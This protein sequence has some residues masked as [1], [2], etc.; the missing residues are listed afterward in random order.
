VPSYA[1]R[2]VC[3]QPDNALKGRGVVAY[4]LDDPPS[5]RDGA[6]QPQRG[7]SE[8]PMAPEMPKRLK[9]ALREA[10]MAAH[11]EELRRALVPLDAAF[12]RWRAGDVGSGELAELIHEFHD[13]PAREL[14]KRYNYGQLDLAVAHA[15]VAGILDRSRLPG[16]LVEALGRAIAFHEERGQT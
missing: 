15:I 2:C 1:W 6:A 10:A 11:E 16:E 4:A 12:Q 8:S 5:K 14:F 7:R 9:R 3:E 13:G